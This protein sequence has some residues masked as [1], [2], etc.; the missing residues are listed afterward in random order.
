MILEIA[1]T[2]LVSVPLG[3][4]LYAQYYSKVKADLLVA[5]TKAETDLAAVKV[6]LATLKGKIP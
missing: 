5:K 4:F 2:A 6:E 1:V 3:A